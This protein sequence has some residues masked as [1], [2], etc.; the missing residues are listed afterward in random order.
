VA[1]RDKMAKR[2]GQ[3]ARVTLDEHVATTV[4]REW[5]TARA[6]LYAALTADAR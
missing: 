4:E 5:Q 2:S 6:W 3:W 1:R